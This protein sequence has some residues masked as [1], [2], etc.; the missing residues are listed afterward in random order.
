MTRLARKGGVAI[1][2]LAVPAAILLALWHIVDG[3]A[4]LARLAQ[5]HPGWLAASAAL[6]AL[7]TLLCTARWR[8]TAKRLGQRLGVG[9]A[10]GEY[11]L[12]QLLNAVLPGGMAG[13]AAR[14]VRVRHSADLATSG[15]AVMLERFA[16]Q[17]SL[18]AVLLP[19]LALT[20]LLPGG[21]RWPDQILTA[22][23]AAAAVVLG[24][25]GVA[26]VAG[27][28]TARLPVISG[29]DTA[30]RQAL[31][32]PGVWPRQA[33]LG[34][35]IVACNLAA[36]WC[37]AEA[38][39]TRLTLEATLTVVPLILTAMLLPVSVGGWGWREGAAAVLF[40]LAGATGEAGLAA[41]IAFGLMVLAGALPGLVPLVLRPRGGPAPLTPP[42]RPTRA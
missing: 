13:D 31:L 1:L 29:L 40:P 19:S 30:A 9:Q 20:L 10:V 12:A 15:Q 32:A 17:I 5:A 34:V 42:D 18:Q 27:R 6:V 35:A 28:L 8:L 21:I 41:S 33:V 11:F 26:L 23:L 22:A 2:R 36:F 37:A 3:P 16:G 4:A 24:V 25:I 14:A 38:T 7:Q 39:G